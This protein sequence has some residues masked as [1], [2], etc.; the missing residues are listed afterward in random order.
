MIPRLPLAAVLGAALLL[1]APYT[2][3]AQAQAAATPCSWDLLAYN[4][5]LRPRS[6]F[7]DRQMERASALVEELEGHDILVLSELFDDRSR[8]LLLDGLQADYPHRT[9]LV[10]EDRGALQDGG[11]MILSRWPIVAEAER[12]YDVCAGSDC[13]A[14]KGLAYARVERGACAVHVL[15]THV[16]A[17]PAPRVRRRQLEQVRA[18]V[19]G[20]GASADEPLLIAGDLNI[21]GVGDEW[22]S[23][24]E[25]LQAAAPPAT[26]G[27]WATFDPQRNVYARGG[28]PRR[29]DHALYSLRH[30]QPSHAEQR[31][32]ELEAAG[33]PLSDH[34]AIEGRF[35]FR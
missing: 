23:A 28:A 13:F 30:L 16:Q 15:G 8:S 11:V 4:T 24:L 20:L 3:A 5:W 14:E 18:F 21:N 6:L 1:P 19:D 27:S 10:G 32:R 2:S 29:L 17:G 12:T 26:E 33:R 34:Y 7:P 35:R 31:T 9:A 22:Q 25:M